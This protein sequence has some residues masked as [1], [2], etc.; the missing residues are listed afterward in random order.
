MIKQRASGI[1]LHVTSLPSKYGIGDLGPEAYR[2]AD[3]LADA[4]Q[5]YW[6]VL[7]LGPTSAKSGC[8][9]YNCLSAFAGNTL[10]ISPELLYEQGLLTEKDV[11]DSPLFPVSRV[12][13]RMAISH[14]TKLLNIAYDRFRSKPR[15]CVYEQFCSENKLWLDDFA[16]FVALRYHFHP[17]LWCNWPIELRD[18]K[19]RALTPLKAQLRDSINR[20]KVLQYLFFKQWHSLKD[21]CNRLDIRIIGDIPI[22]V[23]YDSA[24]V[25]AHPEIF[26]LTKTRTP[27]FVGG[28][29][30]DRFSRTGQLWGNPVYDWKVLKEKGYWW[31]IRRVKHNLSLFDTARIDHFRGLVAYWQVPG[32][33]RTANKGRWVKVP[34][35]FFDTLFEHC[36]PSSIIVE[37]LGYITPDVNACVARLRL[38]STKVIQFAFEGDSTKNT[39]CPHNHARNCVVYTGT[40]DNNTARGWF[41]KEATYLQKNRLFEYLGHK[42]PSAQ[43]HWA[44]IQLAMSSVAKIAVIPMQDVLGLAEQA[45][46]NKPGTAIGNWSW[47][48]YPRQ[49]TLSTA[50]KLARLAEIYGRA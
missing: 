48:L 12:D 16:M 15:S 42:V 21:Y 27:K 1:L 9:P 6:Q 17:R 2:F 36:P 34:E 43:I 29:P 33:S 39:H 8:S 7:P 37:D 11:Q 44:F 32:T 24:D 35:D 30:P 20:E 4:K 14:K 3:F 41:R 45:R 18:K 25:W 13:Y 46:M 10:L 49:M 47:R 40:H 19:R 31:W 28:V 38:S 26:K 5:R 50:R 23:A 22:Y